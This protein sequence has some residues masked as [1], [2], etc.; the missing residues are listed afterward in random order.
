MSQANTAGAQPGWNSRIVKAALAGVVA[1]IPMTVTMLIL[2]RFL[3]RS[4]KYPLPP[5]QI[6]MNVARKAGVKDELNRPQE[7][8]AAT[9]L[10]HFAYGAAAGEFYP[11]VAREL[12]TPGWLSG[13]IYGALVWLF[14]YMGWVPASNLLPPPGDTPARRNL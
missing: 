11:L 8:S 1:T 2:F 14:S 12:P 5:R 10:S 13:A 9:L 6:T 3:P 7:R 4:E